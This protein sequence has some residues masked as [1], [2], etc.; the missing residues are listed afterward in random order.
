MRVATDGG[1]TDEL[2]VHPD[3]GGRAVAEVRVATFEAFCERDQDRLARALALA[4]DSTELG[5]DAT[6]EALTRAWERW[7]TV[8]AYDNPAGWV[9]RVGLNWGR[10]RLRRRRRETLSAFLPDGASHDDV[11]GDDQLARALTTLSSDHR[12]VV[13]AKFYLDWTDGA[14]A[15]ALGVPAGTVKSRLHRAL[16]QL[17]DELRSDP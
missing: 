7:P 1:S 5:R 10:S 2:H 9:Y 16:R 4:L 8:S 3:Q 12:A 15:E 13:V 17:H 6:A 14:T 11:H